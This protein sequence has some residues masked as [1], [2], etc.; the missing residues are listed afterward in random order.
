MF[1]LLSAAT[2]IVLHANVLAQVSANIC[3]SSHSDRAFAPSPIV[4]VLSPVFLLCWRTRISL[5]LTQLMDAV[6][7][8]RQKYLRILYRNHLKHQNV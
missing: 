8:S 2:Q 5:F 4:N 3:K 1:S 6:A 7:M